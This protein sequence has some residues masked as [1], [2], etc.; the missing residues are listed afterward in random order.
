MRHSLRFKV[1]LAFSALTIVLLVAQAL[2]VRVLAE[3]QEEKLIAALIHDDMVSVLRSYHANPSLLPPVDQR[4]N[5]YVSAADKSQFTLPSSVA[6]MSPGTHE[7]IVGDREIHVAIVAF[8]GTRLYRVYDFGTYE[9]HFR[10]MINVLMAGTGLFA[11]LTVWLSFGVAGLLVRQVAGLAQQVKALRHESTA[12]I[13]PGKYREAEIAALVE[14]FNDYHCRMASMIVREKDFTGDVSHELRTPLSAI[15]TS[16]ELLEQDLTI[17]GKSRVRLAQ[18]SRAADGMHLLVDALL[19]L[20]RDA[21]AQCAE[22][23]ELA[24]M[25]ETTLTPFAEQI[26]AS[27]VH[28]Q[29]DVDHSVRVSANPSALSIVLSNLTDN[30]LRHTERGRVCFSYASGWLQI[31]DT[32]VG[33]SGQALPHVFDR[34]YQASQTETAKQGFGIGLS[35][36]KK[37]CDRHGW[38]IQIES[39]PQRGTR[40]SLNLPRS[41][42]TSSDLPSR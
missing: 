21:S 20:A 23:V 37:I 40:V 35:I 6:D 15:K 11:L 8:Q 34:F 5:G 18:I 29:N 30:A 24:R 41:D 19:M 31:E 1:A 9:K 33:I 26:A 10:D 36:V 42:S 28:T 7:I 4:L 39:E 3:A 32:G 27:D 2:G 13:D 25:I 17:S 14:A 16:C 22:T 38:A 12:T